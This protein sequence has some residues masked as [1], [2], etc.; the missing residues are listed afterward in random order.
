MNNEHL[1]DETSEISNETPCHSDDL[2]EWARGYVE[3]DEAIREL[4]GKIK[5]IK[6]RIKELKLKKKN[7]GQCIIGALQA[8]EV[9]ALKISNGSRFTIVRSTRKKPTLRAIIATMEES[10]F[11]DNPEKYAEFTQSALA[12]CANRNSTRLVFRR[13]KNNN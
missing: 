3:V 1:Q 9:D 8:N 12:K 2:V 6:T 7:T 10:V 11:K 5:P 13:R 4:E